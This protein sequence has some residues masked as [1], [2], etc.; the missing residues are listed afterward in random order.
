MIESE[1]ALETAAAAGPKAHARIARHAGITFA[2]TMT[3]NVF[4]YLFYVLVTRTIGVEAYG[5]FASIVAVVLILSAPALI[6]QM[7]VAKLTTDFSRDANRL[8]GLVHAVDRVAMTVSFGAGFVLIALS[9]PLAGFLHVAD[10]LLVT[11]AGL[12]LI[13]AMALPFLRGVLQ[14]TSRF[15]AF[16]LSNV[17][18]NF[19]RALFAPVLGLVA[20]VRGALA[21]MA[22]GYAAAAIYTYVAGRAHRHGVKVPFSLR[23]VA[24]TSAAVALA[25]FCLNVLLLYDVILA[26]RY[27]DAYTAGLYGAAAL[28]ARALYAAIAFVPTVLLPQAAER[29]ARGERTRYLFLQALGLAVVIAVAAIGF[30]ALFPSFVITVMASRKFARAA[31]FLVPFVYA[32]AMLAL[33]NITATY[34][35]ARGRM[36]FVAPLACVALAEIATVALRH[37]SAYDLLQTIAIGHTLAFLACT[38]S[39]GKSSAPKRQGLV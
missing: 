15:S 11:F 33:A 37:R 21:G 4:N 13:G 30:Y 31:A 2:G 22:L 28:A 14:G 10:P 35:I 23:A 26:K 12:S 1:L 3:A 5:T 38:V 24:R 17:A 32:I 19:G 29:A 36:L 8:A 9:V 18:E 27:L 34:N 6:P 25:V 7:V 39:L 16:A 20:G